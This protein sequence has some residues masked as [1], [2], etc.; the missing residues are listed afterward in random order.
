MPPTGTRAPIPRL[1]RLEAVIERRGW[2]LAALLLFLA[3]G[4]MGSQLPE[5]GIYWDEA[6]QRAH[7]QAIL[8]WYA[9]GF[10]DTTVF[11]QGN[12]FLYGG[13]VEMTLEALVA[14]VP[15]DPYLLRHAAV[16][17][18]GL[19]AAWAV[20]RIGVRLDRPILGLLAMALLLVSPRFVGHALF[21]SKDIPTASFYVLTL[22]LFVVDLRRP[23]GASLAGVVPAGVALGLL[24]GTRFGAA[25]ILTAVLAGYAVQWWKDGRGYDVAV[26]LGARFSVAF[27]IGWAVMLVGWPWALRRPLAHP[28]VAL[29]VSGR[30]PWHLD[31]L[32]AGRFVESLDLPV[33]YLPVWFGIVLPEVILAGLVVA[34]VVV[35]RRFIERR[36]LPEAGVVALGLAAVVPLAYVTVSGT[37]LY[38]GVRHLLFLFPLLAL[39]A[40]WG[41]IALLRSAV[42]RSGGAVV[43]WGIVMVAGV[44]L[45]VVEMVRMAPYSY[46][47]FNRLVGGVQGAQGDFELEYW[48]L[49]YRE[50]AQRL[51]D[52][53][54]PAGARIASCSHPASI[55]PFVSD[56]FD[57]VGSLVFGIDGEPDYLLFTARHDCTLAR[58]EGED[59]TLP[60]Q[61]PTRPI[62]ERAGV[63]LLHLITV[64]GA[65]PG[66]S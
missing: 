63:P 21:N 53:G 3:A 29:K 58:Q 24:L 17:A 14:V 20:W 15:A 19:L 4:L 44:A 65:R 23:P 18:L 47:Y 35:L 32:F 64:T 45:P 56:R 39:G 5:Q 6:V 9:S 54:V 11:E 33:S 59:V 51:D 10:T 61:G 50:G 28:L 66:S 48:G 52:I 37:A 43:V 62:V 30:F 7:G 55:E 25:I 57:Y 38:D 8:A 27:L 46:V 36:R 16:M 12:L 26:K 40:A 2:L 31:E 34:V 22:A 41:W 42:L 1:D 49:S 13:I 60:Y